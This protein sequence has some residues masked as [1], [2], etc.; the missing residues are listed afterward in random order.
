MSGVWSS[1][2]HRETALAEGLRGGR[3]VFHEA[4]S[5]A[6]SPC[7]NKGVLF[8][9]LP[10]VLRSGGGAGRE[11]C[12]PRVDADKERALATALSPLAELSL[13]SG[14]HSNRVSSFY[15]ALSL[16]S[17]LRTVVEIIARVVGSYKSPCP[18][19]LYT[20]PGAPLPSNPVFET[21][22]ARVLC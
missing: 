19:K 12:P 20:L 17:S 10:L 2:P 7:Q 15:G 21:Q 8:G 6:L 14:N 13:K 18:P 16:L 4:V 11:V 22:Q 1:S 5:A 9:T 3:A